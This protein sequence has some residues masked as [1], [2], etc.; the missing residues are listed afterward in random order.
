MRTEVREEKEVLNGGQ[1]EI[2]VLI[3]SMEE[4]GS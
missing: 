3:P 2:Q 1:Y 4:G